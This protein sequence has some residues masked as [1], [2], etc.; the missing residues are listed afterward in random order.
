MENITGTMILPEADKYGCENATYKNAENITS[1]IALIERGN[2]FF[3]TKITKVDV[4]SISVNFIMGLQQ[5]N[6]I[7]LVLKFQVVE[8]SFR[9]FLLA[10]YVFRK[11]CER[12]WVYL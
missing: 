2:C 3:H 9:E 6:K 8:T 12:F 5:Q 11:S 10:A 1:W 4:Y 7:C